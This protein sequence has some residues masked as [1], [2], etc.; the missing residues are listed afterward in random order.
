MTLQTLTGIANDIEN[1]DAECS[2]GEH[3]DSGAVWDL[4]H[5]IK[6]RCEMEMKNI[7]DIESNGKGA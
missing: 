7:I 3:T 1:F 2:A 4:L 6:D 5:S